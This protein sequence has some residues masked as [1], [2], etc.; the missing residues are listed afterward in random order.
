MFG[1]AAATPAMPPPLRRA[2]AESIISVSGVPGSPATGLGRVPGTT[3]PHLRFDP[4]SALPPVGGTR[5][6]GGAWRPGG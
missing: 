5:R 4:G 3:L 1:T 6:S 2:G